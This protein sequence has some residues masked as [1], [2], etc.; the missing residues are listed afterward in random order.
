MNKYKRLILVLV[1]LLILFLLAELSGLREHFTLQFIRARLSDNLTTGILMFIVLFSIGNLLHIPGLI[2]LGAA[3][4]ALG[5]LYGGMAT[6][7]AAITSCA[8]SFL[9][10]NLLGKDALRKIDNKTATKLL[11][12]LDTNP[13]RNIVLLRTVFQTLPALNYTLAL[14]GVSFRHYM[15]GTILGLPVP[16]TVYCLFFEQLALILHI[17]Q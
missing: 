12:H 1:F 3:V 10:I 5:Q 4:F 6:Y 7:I 2:F 13:V 11:D 17:H 15:L 16:I 14:S 9:L 8:V